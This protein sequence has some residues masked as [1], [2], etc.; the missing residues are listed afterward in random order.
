MEI[1]FTLITKDTS[2]QLT[3][4]VIPFSLLASDPPSLSVILRNRASLKSSSSNW[5]SYSYTHIR[6]NNLEN[7]IY[8][9]SFY[10]LYVNHLSRLY[11]TVTHTKFINL[12]NFQYSKLIL[13]L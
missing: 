10:F 2:F 13:F 3:S 7:K 1:K 8:L 5:F 4:I 9:I 11:L 6:Y 12:R